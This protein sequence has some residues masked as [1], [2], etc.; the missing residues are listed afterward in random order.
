[1]GFL[2]EPRVYRDP[3][4]RSSERG[5]GTALVERALWLA[6]GVLFGWCAWTVLQAGM[7]QK[8]QSWSLDQRVRGESVS[9]GRFL[10]TRIGLAG[11][12][13]VRTVPVDAGEEEPLALPGSLVGRLEI[14]SLGL[15]AIVLEGD[16]AKTLKLGVGHV[17]GTALPGKRGNA[18]FA[19]HRDTFF[20][21]L[22]AIKPADRIDFTTQRR[23]YRYAVDSVEVVSPDDVA[24]LAETPRPSLTL[25]T[26]YPFYW[27]GNAPK[28]F[29]VHASRVDSN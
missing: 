5:A 29:V 13:P 18:A 8:Y 27:V 21:P 17:P 1:M 2:V 12:A 19:A 10:E 11:E 28:R 24:V 7:Y 16:D 23:T 9:I 20:R 3:F 15:S 26:C 4:W 6:G 14:P 25:V 22:R